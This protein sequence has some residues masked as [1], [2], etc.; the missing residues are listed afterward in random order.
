MPVNRQNYSNGQVQFWDTATGAATSLFKDWS[1]V[2]FSPTDP[3][4]ATIV[5]SK[6]IQ[7][8]KRDS[9]GGKTWSAWG[10]VNDCFIAPTIPA[11]RPDGRKITVPGRDGRIFE[12]DSTTFASP[13]RYTGTSNIKASSVAYCPFETGSLVGGRDNG[14]LTVLSYSVNDAS[15]L[16]CQLSPAGSVR[17][18][19]CTWSPDGKWIA[20]GDDVGDVRLWNA[21]V[22]TNV[23]LAMLLPRRSN[24]TTSLIFLPDST[25]LIII[26]GGYLTVWD[27]AKGDCVADSGLPAMAK[28]IAL[29]GPRNRVGVVINHM[30]SLYELKLPQ[31]TLPQQTLSQQTLAGQQ[32]LPHQKPPA[33]GK[34]SIPSELAEFD[35]TSKV[36]KS[37]PDPFV[38]F[39]FDIYRGLWKLETPRICHHAVAIKALR[40]GFNPRSKARERQEFEG[41]CQSK[42]H[43]LHIS[44]HGIFSPSCSPSV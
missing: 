3:D 34:T 31:Q 43:V 13:V 40:P 17:G 32:R 37:K 15:T 19:V 39:Y 33:K 29:D 5:G 7:L 21:S 28:N 30:I 41:V 16:R 12:Y 8:T 35:I 4:I 36:V 6:G 38:G 25:A 23:S 44:I 26:S 9:P 2:L 27:I 24:P 14:Q 10:S 42:F 1:F 11:F 20:T 22:T 18:S